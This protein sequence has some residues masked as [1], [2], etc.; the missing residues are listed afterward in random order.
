[1]NAALTP[2]TIVI[3][4]LLAALGFA[5]NYLALPIA[6]SV[7][8]IFGSIFSI[9]AIVLLG[10]R[11]GL[12]VAIVAASC[13]YILWHHPYAIIIFAMEALWIG[14]AI[15]RGKTNLVLIDALYWLSLGWL[16]VALF[17]GG[18]MGLGSQSVLIIILKQSI[19]GLFNALVVS[20]ILLFP[21]ITK[22]GFKVSMR[23]S[24]K[25]LIFNVICVFLMLP[26][27]ALLV[28]NSYRENTA[29]HSRVVATVNQEAIEIDDEV[30]DWIGSHI[31][32]VT[33][34]AELASAHSV[35]ASESI[36]SEL[37]RI[38]KLFPDLQSLAITD[39][40][41]T[42]VALS[43]ANKDSAKLVVGLNTNNGLNHKTFANVDQLLISDVFSGANGDPLFSLSAPVKM[44]GDG[45][46]YFARGTLDM[47]HLQADL[48]IHAQKSEL[49]VTLLDHTRKVIISSDDS[50]KSLDQ[51]PEFKGS[52]HKTAI[53]TVFLQSPGAQQ[54]RSALTVL[55]EAYYISTSAIPGSNWSL[56]VEYPLAPLQAQLFTSAING[57]VVVA[58]LFVPMIFIAFAIS[59]YL[60]SPLQLLAQ[61]SADI[62]NQIENNDDIVWPETNIEEV[63]Q[64]VVNF[65]QASRALSSKIGGL[66]D[67]LS[68]ATDSARIGVWDYYVQENK[69]IWDKWMNTL[70]GVD[71][72]QFEGAY[73]AWQKGLHP[74]DRERSNHEIQQALQGKGEFDTE[75]RVIWPSG[76]VRHIKANAQIQRDSD[77]KPV[78][79]IGTNYDITDRKLALAALQEAVK[80]AEVA[81]E[82]KSEFLANM[83][84]EIRTPMN[85]VIGMINL[86]LRTHLDS[87][88][89]H[90]ATTVKSSAESLLGIINDILDFSKVEAG[91]LELEPLV[92]DINVL[93]EDFKHAM[94]FRA[95]DK[96]LA[97]V[98]PTNLGPQCWFNADMGRIRQILTNLVGNAI[99]F[100]E[101]GQIAIHYSMQAKGSCTLLRIEIT[102]T[103]IGL[104]LEQQAKLFDRFSQADG[105]TTRI[106]GGSGLGLAISKQLV[107]LMGGEI[108]VSSELGKGSTFWFTLSL[109]NAQAPVKPELPSLDNTV[110]NE[111][112]SI[113]E[114]PQFQGKALVVDDNN[115]NQTVAQFQLEDFGLEVELAENGLVALQMLEQQPF[116]I[117]FM[118]CQMPV[119]DGF[120]ASRL[121][122]VES[123]TVLN[124]AIP[125]IAMTANAVSGD[126]E[127]CIAVGMD[128]YISKPVDT[129]DLER[130]LKRWL[131]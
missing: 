81:N 8:F 85:G 110:A 25:N 15:R 13:T 45:P 22:L 124:R 121:I 113:A 26:T 20:I 119:M 42:I 24:Y 107:L 95:Q 130:V 89:L 92:F 37:G 39:S 47:Q 16:L 10:Y 80:K 76:E 93:F 17:Y 30:A 57:L 12:L 4:L 18:V 127:K 120:E 87:Q 40:S 115:I 100:T 105:S 129:N 74:D 3:A 41:G 128:D 67:R 50:R 103:G 102:D 49:V 126:R 125:I 56:L 109:A 35:E 111:Q 9:L 48:K 61:I 131:A 55:K 94:S 2:K 123:S 69:L 28:F 52:Q 14:L 116:D 79:M 108:G 19:N 75:F 98:C 59:N 106:Y 99:K 34:A 58:L 64:L 90:F 27:L 91:K 70:Y 63:S 112:E 71:T 84:H 104:S 7:S 96:G 53:P 46:A 97:L 44:A 101:R 122:R 5:G 72:D 78:R 118:D 86:L 21:A 1:M 77:G 83:S 38:Q 29:L 73:A 11:W 43:S 82:A 65:Q 33:A 31:S 23:H 88:Q 54:N 60:T 117:V 51:W 66:S 6:L 32:A 114:P 62:P 36:A 68:L